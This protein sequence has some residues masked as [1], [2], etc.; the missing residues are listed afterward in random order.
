MAR[1][2][3]TEEQIIGVL[4]EAETG[5]TCPGRSAGACCLGFVGDGESQTRLETRAGGPG[6]R[7]LGF[8]SLVGGGYPSRE[9]LTWKPFHCH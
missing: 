1:K 9:K 6:N 3:Y 4:N 8:P 2:R 7:Q 5:T